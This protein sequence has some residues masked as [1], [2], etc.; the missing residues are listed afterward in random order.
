V[1]EA[2]GVRRA[3]S[4]AQAAD[5]RVAV[6]D[7]SANELSVDAFSALMPGDLVAMA[8]SDLRRG[9][10]S[11]AARAIA[12]QRGFA[13]LDLSSKTGAGVDELRAVIA[14]Q[15]KQTLGQEGAPALTRVRHRRLVDIALQ[16]VRGAREP[17]QAELAAE[18]LRRAGDALGR[19]TGRIDV[20]Q[21]LDAIFADFCIG[22]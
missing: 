4:R 16:G 6:L 14:A 2:E 11:S 18:D 5:L 22:K 9:A 13:T 12:V 21:V 3:L 8:K 20:E 7:S 10:A 15:V 1:I 17:K 19:I